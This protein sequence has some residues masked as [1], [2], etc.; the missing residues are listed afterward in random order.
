M[1]ELMPVINPA[2]AAIDEDCS[3][4]ASS[5]RSPC[6]CNVK[7]PCIRSYLHASFESCSADGQ[8]THLILARAVWATALVQASLLES[9]PQGTERTD[10]IELSARAMRPAFVSRDSRVCG[11]PDCPERALSSEHSIGSSSSV[12]YLQLSWQ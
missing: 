6:K 3:V 2:A 1:P 7:R 8:Q 12:P 11:R 10:L 4:K 9:P 5:N